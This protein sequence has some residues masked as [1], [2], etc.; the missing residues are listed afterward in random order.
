MDDLILK[1]KIQLTVS[2]VQNKSLQSSQD[3]R[4]LFILEG[5]MH[6]SVEGRQFELNSSDLFVINTNQN[7]SYMASDDVLYVDVPILFYLVGDIC[8]GISSRF[9]CDSTTLDD[10]HI[11]ELRK[12]V[13]ELLFQSAYM[14]KENPKNYEY[15]AFYY[16]LIHFLTSHFIVQ[17]NVVYMGETEARDERRRIEIDA[18]IR[19]NYSLPIT[20]EDLAQKLFLS[21]NYLSRYFSKIYGMSFSK[22]LLQVR[23]TNTIDEFIYGDKPI[24]RI[25]HDNGFES[26][27]LFNKC[28]KERFG[29]TPTEFK[30][31]IAYKAELEIEQGIH[32]ADE[33]IG[34]ISK[35]LEAYQHL[36]G[37]GRKNTPTA[38]DSYSV[39]EVQRL[40]P[41]WNQLINIGEAGNLLD[42]GIQ[43]HTLMLKSNF[44]F[45]YIRFWNL[46]SEDLF[47]T[48]KENYNF[49]KIDRIFD[50]ILSMDLKPFID[51]EQKLNRINKTIGEFIL[52]KKT[53]VLFSNREEWL[54]A[55]S[56]L[57]FHLEKRYGKEEVSTWI[58]EVGQYRF[59]ESD[60]SDEC[61]FFEMF[62]DIYETVKR[63]V[64][65]MKVGGS[66]ASE[67]FQVGGMDHFMFLWSQEEFQPDFVTYM[68]YAY[69]TNALSNRYIRRS[70]DIHFFKG[71]YE[72]SR[73]TM[74]QAGMREVPLYIME[75]NLTISDR[76]IINDSCFKGAY[77]VQTYL[78][79]YDKVEILGYFWGSDR[80]S[81]Y[82]D[83]N[84][85]THGGCGLLT[86][87]GIFKPAAFAFEFLNDLFPYYIGKE[88]FYL[89]T[90]NQQNQY[91]MVC[92]NLKNLNYTYYVTEEENIERENI[93]KYYEN[94]DKMQLCICL[95]DVVNGKYQ[96]KISRINP[97]SGSVLHVWEELGYSTEFS[98][99]DIKYLRNACGPKLSM[100]YI[101]VVDNKL[102]LSVEMMFNEI[103]FVS[104]ELVKAG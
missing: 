71:Y 54:N 88:N 8:N 55:F 75:W 59:Y 77:I 3:A 35:R 10:Y 58:L 62:H 43:E 87:D 92:H 42:G 85:L 68:A 98:R 2:N 86:V 100:Y 27:S 70:A 31:S 6:L 72:K 39:M 26:I 36:K 38:C 11:V 95:K 9:L 57:F 13:K 21:K 93:T 90:T 82:T 63:C 96:I 16:R 50:F 22:Y 104:A 53:N 41:I 66:C 101:E 18:Y 34:E 67:F 64:P 51:L 79:L 5:S 89:I 40:K 99:K 60:L 15:I 65:A 81:E 37:K 1:K 49:S 83:S 80:S 4:L 48:G 78:D 56:A 47:V 84:E 61:F 28:F 94:L 74:D 52:L 45:R 25:A 17:S 30:N 19:A 46:F 102:F 20:L 14:E 69:E 91:R 24:I 32:S 33:N 97:E 73:R 103:A 23:L 44:H 76:N 29:K 7:Y 12:I